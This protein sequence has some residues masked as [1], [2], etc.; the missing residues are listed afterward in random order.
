MSACH[1]SYADELVCDAPSTARY[2]SGLGTTAL[3][4]IPK[5]PIGKILNFAQRQ[6]I[7]TA[8]T[9]IS[10]IRHGGS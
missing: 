3:A 1:H 6:V 7:E 4:A 2:R 8:K 5:D 10:Y 9:A